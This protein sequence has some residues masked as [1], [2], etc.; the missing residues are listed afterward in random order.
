[1]TDKRMRPDPSSGYLRRTYKFYQGK[2]VFEFGHELSYSTYSYKFV[3][4]NQNKLN[5]KIQKSGIDVDSY[6]KSI[7]STIVG[8]E[9]VGNV[10][11]KHPVLLFLRRDGGRGDS[12]MK[13]LIEF[14]TVRQHAN[15][16]K[17]VKF[18]VNP[19]EQFNRLRRSNNG[20]Q[21]RT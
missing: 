12:P 1:M 4:V 20:T 9:N 18:E 5:F 11:G 21:S 2:K 14:E 17:N 7:F 15:E 16:K 10:A 19:C 8:I 6:K 3:S 13:Q